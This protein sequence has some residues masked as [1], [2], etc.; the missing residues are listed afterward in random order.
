MSRITIS[1]WLALVGGGQQQVKAVLTFDIANEASGV[2]L[3][4]IM[5]D[6][7]HFNLNG[8]SSKGALGNFEV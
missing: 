4:F 6:R 8:V 2:I 5:N 3:N 7:V 1:D